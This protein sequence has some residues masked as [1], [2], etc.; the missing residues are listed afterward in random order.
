MRVFP[1][2]F[3]AILSYLPEISSSETDGAVATSGEAEF[4]S[5]WET[6]G[7]KPQFQRYLGCFP[8]GITSLLIL[9]ALF[10]GIIEVSL[11]ITLDSS[12]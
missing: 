7:E 1:F 11:I 3:R 10:G 2:C 5:R 9:N 12:P 6:L 8:S 4:C